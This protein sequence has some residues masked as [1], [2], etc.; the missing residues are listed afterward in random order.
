MIL[1]PR[2]RSRAFRQNS[3][4]H[5]DNN[6]ER[7]FNR[8]RSY[9]LLTVTVHVAKREWLYGTIPSNVESQVGLVDQEFIVPHV[10]NTPMP[11]PSKSKENNGKATSYQTQIR[12]GR[13]EAIHRG[14]PHFANTGVRGGGRPTAPPTRLDFS[15][16]RGGGAGPENRL[17]A[18]S[19]SRRHRRGC[20]TGCPGPAVQIEKKVRSEFLPY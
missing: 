15:G 7:V 5:K 18:T 6:S 3:K 4:T 12:R 16:R 17:G 10:Q 9:L 20:C 13:S 1:S 19:F 8:R 11:V 2:S 14:S